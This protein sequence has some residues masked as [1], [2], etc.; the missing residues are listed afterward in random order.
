MKSSVYLITNEH[1]AIIAHKIVPDD[2]RSHVSSMLSDL[3]SNEQTYIK[4]IAFFTD[5]V[6]ADQQKLS[7]CFKKLF[8]KHKINILQVLF[9]IILINIFTRIFIMHK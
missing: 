2:T 3:Y 6:A 1:N 5:N 9:N 7:Q 8:P 4:P